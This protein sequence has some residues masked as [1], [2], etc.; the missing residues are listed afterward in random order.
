MAY[1]YFSKLSDE[2]NAKDLALQSA[3]NNAALIFAFQND[4]S[5]YQIIEGQNL[6]PENLNPL[7]NLQTEADTMEYLDSVREVVQKCVAIMPEH[8]A[9]IARYCKARS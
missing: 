6:I 7:V 1:L 5:F 8:A 4:K 3:T 2:N 9:Y